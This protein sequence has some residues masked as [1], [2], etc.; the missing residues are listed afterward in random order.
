MTCHVAYCLHN[1]RPEHIYNI[2]SKQ[3]PSIY[4]VC[5]MY[6]IFTN[7]EVNLGV[8]VATYSVCGT[9]GCVMLSTCQN[10]CLEKLCIFREYLILNMFWTQTIHVW[11]FVWPFFEFNKIMSEHL[12]DHF[13]NSKN[14]VRTFFDHFWIQKIMS[15]HVFDFKK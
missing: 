12:F 11:T 6:W 10:P 2:F 4:P 14:N 1:D 15:E 13:L 7:F 8:N 5:A 9:C 3:Y